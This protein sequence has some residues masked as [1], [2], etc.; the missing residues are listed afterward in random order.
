VTASLAR[1][2]RHPIKAIGFEELAEAVL[3]PGAALPEDRRWAVAHADCRL[4]EGGGWARKINF[5]RG[6]S[7]PDLMAIS[8]RL[9]ADGS[10]TLTHPRAAAITLNPDLP[11]D[12][13]RLIDWLRPLWPA[14]RAA[15]DRVVHV[16]GQAMTDWPDPFVSVLNVA[17]LRALGARMGRDLSI[18]RWRGNLWIEGLEPWQEFDLTGHEIT[19]GPARLRIDQRITR[20]KATTV[21]PETGQAD[22]DTLA[23]LK[24]GFGHQDFGVYATVIVGGRIACG[25]TVTL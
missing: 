23:A 14:G 21:N 6:V 17:S 10:L 9:A 12:A 18:H 2:C 16:P 5:L 24:T 4:P 19:I 13:A 1:I 15:P 22:A 3:T 8:A 11:H 25:D 20:C 7:G